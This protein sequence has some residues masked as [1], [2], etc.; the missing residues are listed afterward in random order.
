[1]SLLASHKAVRAYVT[2]RL[3]ARGVAW[4]DPAC[5]DVVRGVMEAARAFAVGGGWQ[6]PA[7]GLQGGG[8]AGGGAGGEEGKATSSRDGGAFRRPPRR[9]KIMV[10]KGDDRYQSTRPPW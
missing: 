2:A 4:P 10:N 7:G 1:M 9:P 6:P 8:G 3:A 5:T